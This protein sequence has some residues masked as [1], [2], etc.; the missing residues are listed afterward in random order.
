MEGVVERRFIQGYGHPYGNYDEMFA[1][2]L[3][4][5]RFFPDEFINRYEKLGGDIKKAVRNAA[6]SVL[7]VVE[8]VNTDEAALQTLLPEYRTLK[9]ALMPAR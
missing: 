6:N 2:A 4:V 5:F 1:S 7:N 9:T 3:T 8:T